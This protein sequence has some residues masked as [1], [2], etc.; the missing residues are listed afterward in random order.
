MFLILITQT[1]RIDFFYQASAQSERY[2][3]LVS[4]V[5]DAHTYKKNR[6]KIQQYAQDIQGYLD[7][8]R[9]VIF[10]AD[11]HIT[12]AQIAAQ[13]EK[14]YYEGDGSSGKQSILVGTILIGNIPLPMVQSDT[15]I[16]PSVY[17]YVDFDQKVFVYNESLGQYEKMSASRVT[18][19]AVEIWHGVIN[20]AVGRAWDPEAD[21]DRIA[22]FLDKTHD[23]Y[24][25]SGKFSSDL[26]QNTPPRVF[27]YDG[28][29]E[30]KSADIRSVFQY[31]LRMKNIENLA[32][33]RYSKY[34]LGDI[35]R[36]IL[37]YDRVRDEEY[38]QS[39]SELG[40][41]MGGKNGLSQDLIDAA[42]DIQTMTVIQGLLKKF[43]EIVNKK[44]LG[45]ELLAVRNAGRYSSGATVLADIGPVALT[46]TDEVAANILK[47]AND[48]LE[49]SIDTD[50]KEKGYARRV[51]IYEKVRSGVGYGQRLEYTNYFFGTKGK[52]VT[53][54]SLCTI[55]R[56]STGAI[57]PFGRDILVEANTAFDVESVDPHV[58]KLKT[59]TEIFAR[60]GM[61]CFSDDRAKIESYWGGNSMLRVVREGTGTT[62]M[63][64]FEGF[65]EPQKFRGFSESIRSLAGMKESDRL[66]VASVSQCI[67]PRF[68]YTL[69]DPHL[70]LEED[71]SMA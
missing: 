52:D 9:A 47:T 48:A 35:N 23:F 3:Q 11:Q 32:Y 41:D 61:Q 54:A 8:A 43:H 51:P 14:L 46:L 1:I 19:E 7:G 56:G 5:V 66:P 38:H 57:H 4:I 60:Y 68:Q 33:N 29:I 70:Y 31:A 17:P 18:H 26:I 36:A 27:Y 58:E 63:D 12:P 6:S 15:G 39:L 30:S 65:P 21:P 13:N 10:V 28:F 71:M 25:K 24:T 2:E 40:I 69:K 67:D 37:E 20:P 45:E 34:L 62:V 16:F 42:P 53:D 44:T 50:L 49:K 59:D 64:P 55:A 22:Q